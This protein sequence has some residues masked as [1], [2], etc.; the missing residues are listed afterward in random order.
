MDG[1]SVE[2][3]HLA[4]RL[5]IAAERDGTPRNVAIIQACETVKAI[6]AKEIAD[7]KKKEGK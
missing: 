1:L 2:Q 5:A 4:I 6:S 3:F 7:R